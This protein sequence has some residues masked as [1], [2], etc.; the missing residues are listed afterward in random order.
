VRE[1]PWGFV[2]REQFLYTVA[3]DM[4]FEKAQVTLRTTL[5]MSY[6]VM[7]SWAHLDYLIARLVLLC[8]T[9]GGCVWCLSQGSRITGPQHVALTAFHSHTPQELANK[10]K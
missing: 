6:L 7:G 3:E 9:E 5:R 1:V 4:A 8:S 2:T 10:A